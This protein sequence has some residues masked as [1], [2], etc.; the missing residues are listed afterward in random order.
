MRSLSPLAWLTFLLFFNPVLSSD[1]ELS[2]I[3]K[4]DDFIVIAHRGATGYAPENTLPAIKK[5]IGLGANYIEID[6]H[7]SKDEAVVVI[8]D[9]SVDRTTNGSGKVLDL[10]LEELKT[11]DAGSWYDS[12]FAGTQI[13]TLD[14]AIDIT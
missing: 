10:T 11:L 12:S 9:Y 4:Q 1:G 13:P 6:V 5:A 2:S 8:H 14:E 7:Q 3:E